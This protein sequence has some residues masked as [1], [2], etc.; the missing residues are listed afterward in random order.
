MT[1]KQKNIVCWISLFLILVLLT[2][3]LNRH[4]LEQ[5][6]SVRIIDSSVQA[7]LNDTLTIQQ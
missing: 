7:S 2:F 6:D 4:N 1:T 5:Y 3:V